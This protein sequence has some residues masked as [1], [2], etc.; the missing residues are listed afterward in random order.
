MDHFLNR[1]QKTIIRGIDVILPPRCPVNG[2]M[3]DVHGMISGEVWQNLEFVSAPFCGCCGIPF[4]FDTDAHEGQCMACI[5]KPPSYNSARSALRYND[6]S[7][8][9][10]LGFKHGDKTHSVHSFTPWLKRAGSDMLAQA[11]F[12]IPVPLHRARLLSRRYN[13]AGVIADALS[14]DT[15]VRHLPLSLKRVRAT[16]SQ[17]HLKTDERIQNVRKAFAVRKQY[18]SDL[19]GKNIVL[20]DDVYTTGATVNECTKVLKKAGVSRVD[21]LTLA[22][23]V[24][25]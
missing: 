17:G 7:R 21:I 24:K 16:P 22:R 14:K 12:L 2:D 11:D 15:G 8:N 1:T 18:E 4:D 6:T 19:I 5:T 23:V 25:G 10:I 3:V 20:I 9:I 13:Q